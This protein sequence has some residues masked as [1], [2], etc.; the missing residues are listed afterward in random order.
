MMIFNINRGQKSEELFHVIRNLICHQQNKEQLLPCSLAPPPLA[1]AKQSTTG[2][3]KTIA[4]LSALKA[5][6]SYT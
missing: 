5:Q 3:E 6:K 1:N 2:T 4:L